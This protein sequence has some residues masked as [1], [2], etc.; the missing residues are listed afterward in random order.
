M[1]ADSR[2]RFMHIC[3]DAF[4]VCT[5]ACI[6]GI[7]LS[8]SYGLDAVFAALALIG[9]VL[10]IG[11]L[12]AHLGQ[13]SAR[14]TGSYVPGVTDREAIGN[15]DTYNFKGGDATGIGR[16]HHIS[17]PKVT[18]HDFGKADASSHNQFNPKIRIGQDQRGLERALKMLGASNAE[19][20]AL[21]SQQARSLGYSAAVSAIVQRLLEA[22]EG[23]AAKTVLLDELLA[24]IQAG[25]PLQLMASHQPARA[26]WSILPRRIALPRSRQQ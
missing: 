17:D 7:V 12:G 20:R 15:G 23:E 16:F 8:A 2:K 6:L 11:I 10:F 18:Q 26:S 4:L 9:G 24:G 14:L 22:N 25:E 1:D 21:E 5:V 13:E 3:L 19:L